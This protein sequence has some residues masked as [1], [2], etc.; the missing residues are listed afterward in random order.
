[1]SNKQKKF[2]KPFTLYKGYRNDTQRAKAKRTI[3]EVQTSNNLPNAR[4]IYYIKDFSLPFAFCFVLLP[5]RLKNKNYEKEHLL[6][7]YGHFC[8]IGYS[9]LL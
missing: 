3:T 8:P 4:K 7:C 9:I 2:L 1:M 6:L 5:R